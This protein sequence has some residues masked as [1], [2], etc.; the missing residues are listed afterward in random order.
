MKIEGKGRKTL[1][2]PHQPGARTA[3]EKLWQ[4]EMWL[5]KRFRDLADRT[6]PIR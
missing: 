4:Y 5:Q 6:V 2:L 1:I 3:Q